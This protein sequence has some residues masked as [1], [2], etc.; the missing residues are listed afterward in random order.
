MSEEYVCFVAFRPFLIY[1]VL[2]YQKKKYMSEEY[3]KTEIGF[4]ST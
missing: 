3:K 4:M 2:I 1:F